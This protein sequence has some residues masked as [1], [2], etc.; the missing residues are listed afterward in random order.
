MWEVSLYISY[1]VQKLPCAASEASSEIMYM[2]GEAF[3]VAD[4]CF[5]KKANLIPFHQ[6][7]A[8]APKKGCTASYSGITIIKYFQKYFCV[9]FWWRMS[10]EGKG[11]RKYLKEGERLGVHHCCPIH[12]LLSLPCP[13]VLPPGCPV[14]PTTSC[15]WNVPLASLCALE[16]VA[17]CSSVQL[18]LF[19]VPATKWLL[20]VHCMLCK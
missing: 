2:C 18:P 8:A 12:I 13:L 6:C 15:P 20:L 3:D 17:G 9:L 11:G 19:I 4:N 5:Y 1:L 7:G 16:Q 14:P 10:E